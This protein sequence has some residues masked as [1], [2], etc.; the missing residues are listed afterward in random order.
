MNLVLAEVERNSKTATEFKFK[1]DIVVPTAYFPSIEYIACHHLTSNTFIEQH[2]TYPKQTLRNRCYI[3]TSQGIQPLIIPVLKKD[4]PNTQINHIEIMHNSDFKKQ[5][6]KAIKTAY[7]S[8]PFFEHY[9]DIISE[10]INIKESNLIK[11]NSFIFSKLCEIIHLKNKHY[12]TSE[13]NKE[14]INKT[15]LRVQLCSKKS[16]T[17]FSIINHKTQYNQVFIEKQ[18]F[19]ENLSIIDLI[20][21]EGPMAEI[22]IKKIQLKL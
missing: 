21:N 12:F 5:H 11:Y 22:Y 10:C 8:S 4:G 1:M 18:G 20:M 13:F 16:V 17:R 9:I 2:E 6:I 7:H 3:A 14:L 15:D 19:I